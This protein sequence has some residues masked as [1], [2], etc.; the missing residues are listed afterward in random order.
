M[1]IYVDV[2]STLDVKSAEKAAKQIET[3]FERAAKAASES[4][5]KILN[6]ELKKTADEAAKAG[7]QVEQSFA[8]MGRKAGQ[9]FSG[10]IEKSVAALN[11]RAVDAA[12]SRLVGKF[13]A[14]GKM[15]GEAFSKA[16]EAEAKRLNLDAGAIEAAINRQLGV[17]ARRS[18]RSFGRAFAG[19]VAMSLPG[20]GMVLS[21]MSGQQG[22]A[23]KAG[24]AAGRVFG[25][26]FTT[27][28]AA[29]I[30][31]IGYTL[32]KGFERYKSL[33]ATAHRFGAMG[34]SAEQV[35]QIMGDLN[36][37]VSGTPIAL[38][39]AAAAATNFMQSGV[40]EG[41]PL[42]TAIQAIADAAG[43]SGSRFEDLALIF[44]QVLNKGK[45][46]AEEMM[47]LN[48]RNIPIQAALRKEFNLTGEEL[49]KMSREGKISF[50]MMI[51][52]VEA[53]WG[54][55]AQRMGDTIEGAQSR[56]SSAVSRIGANAI[57]ALFGDPLAMTED[58][59]ELAKVFNNIAERLEEVN[60]W[61]VRNSDEI[62][63]WASD[64][65][66]AAK[67]VGTTLGAIVR[68]LDDI[69]LGVDDVVTAFLAW[70]T[71]SGVIKLSEK[72][73]SIGDILSK[74]LPAQAE[75][76]A[77][78]IGTALSKVQVP[79]WLAYLITGEID[80]NLRETKFDRAP[81]LYGDQSGRMTPWQWW[82][83]A[84]SDPA[85]H[86]RRRE[87]VEQ[88]L[89]W[90]SEDILDREF[91]PPWGAPGRP[92]T[93]EEYVQQMPELRP[94][95][96]GPHRGPRQPGEAG[97]PIAD[98]FPGS[99][100]DGQSGG[101]AGGGSRPVLPYPAGYGEPPRPG[102]SL[103]QWRRRMQGMRLQHEVSERQ[104]ALSEAEASGDQNAVVA[105]RNALI[106]AQMQLQEFMRESATASVAVPPPAGY[107]EAPIP[108]E[109]LDVWKHRQEI[110]EAQ[111]R[112]A[113]KNAEL[114]A[115]LESGTASY[116]EIIQ[117]R[118]EAIDAELRV[119]ELQNR[120][121][122]DV[123]DGL[124]Q[125]GAELDRDF[126]I[127]KGLAGIAENLTKFLANL[128]A[129]PVLGALRAIS[130]AGGGDN[131]GSG[132]IGIAANLG[133]FG[134]RFQYGG[135]AA[136]G[137]RVGAGG[138]VPGAG[139]TLP[140]AAADGRWGLMEALAQ[141]AHG[142]RY[143]W[144]A[145][146]LVNGL[147]DCSGAISDLVEV[148]MYGQSSPGRLFNTES[149]PQF[150]AEHGWRRGFMPGALNVGVRH[151]GPGGGHMAATLPS[152]VNFEAGGRAG[153]ISYGGNAAG[154]LDFPEQWYYLPG[155][156]PAMPPTYTQT[157]PSTPVGGVAPTA[158]VPQPGAGGG[159]G[160]GFG[161]GLP[162]LMPPPPRSP[163]L[164]Q[165]GQ[166]GWWPDTMLPG[167]GGA[168]A[169]APHGAAAG[170]PPGPVS[171]QAPTQIGGVAPFE[172]VGPG[173][174]GF[175]GI[176]TAALQ[177][178]VGAGAAAGGLAIDS[179]A[180]GAGTAAAAAISA[181]ANLGIQLANRAIGF[182]GQAA[183]IGVQG[184]METFLPNA[185]SE[186]ANQNWFTRIIGGIAGA[187]PAIPNLA[188][189]SGGD[190]GV[191]EQ[192]PP[193]PEDRQQP[194]QDGQPQGSGDP[195]ENAQVYIENMNNNR[196]DGMG[197][198]GDI[199]WHQNVAA[200]AGPGSGGR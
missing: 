108:G 31:A 1:A 182:A 39:A 160:G 147:A 175:G 157:A 98:L 143:G 151:G 165:P 112:A 173:F 162:G 49:E 111:W 42:Q 184:L 30:G 179:Q 163:Q 15:S 135:G 47:Q 133:A 43:A 128:G 62:K 12:A 141:R 8:Q 4:V 126:G 189:G 132:L 93:F 115:L 187:A 200:T 169:G 148:L 159:G 70:K 122:K 58:A 2:I 48:E 113:Q 168:S 52:A 170:M 95:Y 131:A 82:N 69:G 56:I 53:E 24:A 90:P 89:G 35:K 74:T 145:S 102:E 27:A 33:D 155:A 76:G 121:L 137:L 20:V 114:N 191:G 21:S 171:A 134:P 188:G 172:G 142:G 68:V 153:G 197:V 123:K 99:A 67:A 5:D 194:G 23:A 81:H 100:S 79:V 41:R 144:G 29:G 106:D 136:G 116:E 96:N 34:K 120:A 45:L 18:G 40:R 196:T 92:A 59:G 178:G 109:S 103:D 199:V 161:A 37:V 10:G 154:A 118:K 85:E 181:A 3:T 129:A 77:R 146:D 110:L 190:A 156:A 16:I 195:R 107:G 193:G 84:V 127:S 66:D 158:P 61:I 9:G 36:D 177:T 101:V 176:I 198:A 63:A 17:T 6:D 11:T 117:A 75:K 46:Q 50:G 60:Q 64:A 119:F 51:Q 150:A 167:G 152:G 139:L 28:A 130:N 86:K 32:F 87:W 97:G 180:P 174:T 25:L 71:I 13:T 57:A 54:G 55:M 164:Q 72:L 140:A 19:E 80:E 65:A 183:G 94:G 125:I 104:A 7:K 14:A 149:F 124:G 88:N 22:V 91:T 78:G 73:L 138:F 185:G 26:A 44:Q 192:K 166:R 186:L 38:D 83:R 105:A